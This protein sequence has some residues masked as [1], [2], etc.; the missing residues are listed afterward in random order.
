MSEAVTGGGAGAASSTRAGAWR[1]GVLAGLALA[2]LFGFF[3]LAPIAQD[4]AYH[5]FADGR[6]W[7]GVPN[8]ANVASNLPFAVVG[9]WGLSWLR[10]ERTRAA[11]TAR[12]GRPAWV[13]F[14]F[15]VLAVT[16]GSAWYHLR[17]DDT[18]LVWDR[19]PMTLGFTGLT[20][21]VLGE[22]VTPRAA[23]L[24]W[25]GLALG[26]ASVIV[27]AATGDLRLYYG[28]QLMPMVVAAAALSLFRAPFTHTWLLGIAV[29]LYAAA[30][31]VEAHDVAIWEATAG[32]IGG[33]P[34]KHLLAAGATCCVL[35]MLRARRPSG[36]VGSPGS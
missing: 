35:A 17:P 8:F 25:P 15:G 2:S 23:R 9:A 12:A 14:F 24:L 32:L 22:W 16:G 21:A 7:L 27:W 3:L 26:A 11:S 1:H 13:V 10:T 6:A 30:K 19:L 31:V 28:V 4:Q 33:H 34:L 29:L 18:S 20:V 36:A 5:R